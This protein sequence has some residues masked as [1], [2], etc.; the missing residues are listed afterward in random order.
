MTELIEAVTIHL[1]RGLSVMVTEKANLLCWNP[2]ECDRAA[3]EAWFAHS[4][5]KLRDRVAEKLATKGD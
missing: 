4:E 5:G 2:N 3:L 1:S